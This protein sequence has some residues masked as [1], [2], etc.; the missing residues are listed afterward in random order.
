MGAISIIIA[1]VL[2]AYNSVCI[3]GSMEATA[4]RVSMHVCVVGDEIVVSSASFQCLATF[5]ENGV[6]DV[7]DQES[8]VA[9]H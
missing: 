8:L 6:V 4:N 3:S 1:V 2:A 5:T 9:R 7:C